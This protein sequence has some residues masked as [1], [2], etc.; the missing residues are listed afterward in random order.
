M[1][2]PIDKLH[3]AHVEAV[4][5]ELLQSQQNL[6]AETI[7]DRL[8]G[9][10]SIKTIQKVLDALEKTFMVEVSYKYTKTGTAWFWYNNEEKA[11]KSQ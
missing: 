7:K 9:A 2:N 1:K 3:P 11:K 4:L 10:L 6:T 5:R 8:N